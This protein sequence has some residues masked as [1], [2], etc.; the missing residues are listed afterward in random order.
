[1]L[2]SFRG[3]TPEIHE[4]AFV[5][6]SAQ[7]IGDVKIGADSSIWFNVVIRGDVNSIRIG[8]RTNIQDGCILHVTIDT[9]PIVIGDNVTIGHGVIV[10]GCHIRSNCLIGMGSII[11][12]GAEIGEN[13]VVAAGAI[14]SEW[15]KI[16]PNT[17]VMGAP[18]KPKRSV[19]EKD[20]Q[21]ARA[22]YER[23][24]LNKEIYKKEVKKVP[25][26]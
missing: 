13:C 20:L 25:E 23:Y 1:M 10:H 6:E 2:K 7:V 3:V 17:V 4:T 22:G 12:D 16:P 24:L 26:F 19:T 18:A 11:L 9:H 8:E 5:E 15:S 14:V 21:R